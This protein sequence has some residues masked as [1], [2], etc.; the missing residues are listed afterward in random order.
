[1]AFNRKQKLRDNIEAIRTAFILDRENRTATTEERAILQR[2]CGFGGLKCILNPAKELTDAVRW[3]KSD[4]ELFAPTVELHRLIRENSK[5]ETEYK[6][7]VDSLK[8]SVLTAFYTPKEITDTIA[9][10]LADYSVRPARM[11]E[12][13][14]G[15]GVFVDSMLRH[16][17]NADVM[18]FEKDLL[19][20]T[21]L[22]HLYPDQ[23]MRTCGFEK[24]ERPFNN[25][26]DLAVSNIPFGD[27]AVFDAEFQRS[28]SFG[29]RSAQKTIHNYFFLKGLDA[30]RDGGIVA[31]I[32]SQGVLNSTKTSVRNELFSQA[33]LV[34]AIRLPNNLFTDNAGTEV[35]S[36]LIVLQ[37]NLS[38]KEMSQDE[39]LMTV[40][41]TDTKTALTDN[42]YFIHHP[43]RIVHTMAKLDTDPYGKPAMV[44]LHEGK[45]AGIAG[46]LRRMLDEDFH[47]RLAMRLY[48]GSIRQ[49]GTE[50]KV[51][52]QKEV[53]RTA[54]KMETTSSMQAVE[55]PTEKPQP[56]EEKPEIEPHRPMKHSD[57]V[58]LSLLD[59]WGM[60]EEVSKEETSK[61]KKAAKKESAAK[62]TASKPKVQVTPKVTNIPPHTTS[63]SLAEKKTDEKVEDFGDTETLSYR[64][65][66]ERAIQFIDW[67]LLT[68]D[69]LE[70]FLLAH[71]SEVHRDEM[72]ALGT[73][74]FYKV[75]EDACKAAFGDALNK[76]LDDL[77]FTIEGNWSADSQKKLIEIIPRPQWERWLGD[78]FGKREDTDTLIPDTITI[79]EGQGGERV[80]CIYDAKH[81]VPS[82]SGK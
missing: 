64:L 20:G 51:T 29:R 11:L 34:S 49:S 78:N 75:W 50:E 65:E 22:R 45:A 23:K 10:V 19:T 21:I 60:T 41:Q 74:A 81:Y 70:R 9:D 68:I 36:D 26:F 71:E 42:A 2:Y 52:V 82:T 69:L 32:T 24:I 76:R 7:F 73:T 16:S 44:Y 59:L 63:V 53:E 4:L 56:T 33:N 14:A 5:D 8:A 17:P 35:G 6:R 54:I 25:Y 37:K 62:R 61:K 55:T 27:I 43:E 30:V 79:A 46:D 3:A 47:Y 77:G 28:D 72:Q 1:M 48:S 66:H 15:V 13:S 40:I 38:K 12:P 31:F 39:R 58:Q 57:G 80:L 18:A 67:K